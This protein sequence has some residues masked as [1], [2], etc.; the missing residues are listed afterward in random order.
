MAESIS[1][2]CAVWGEMVAERIREKIKME[3]GVKKFNRKLTNDDLVNI[4]RSSVF[5]LVLN[6]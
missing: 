5:R 3:S 2:A 1:C 4:R 6:V